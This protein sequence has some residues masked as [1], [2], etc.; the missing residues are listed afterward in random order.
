MLLKDRQSDVLITTISK[1]SN[2]HG[3]ITTIKNCAREAQQRHTLNIIS[4][5][6]LCRALAA[7]VLLSGNLKNCSDL[8]SCHWDCTGEAGSIVTEISYEGKVKG[9][10]DNPHLV[11][12][13]ESFSSSEG[14]D[15][16]YYIGSGQLHVARKTFD[17]RPFYNSITPLDTG[18]IAQDVS[19]Y[20]D[21]SLQVQ[22]ILNLG[23]SIS[24]AN[25]IEACG[26]ILLQAMPDA[27]PDE[28]HRLYEEFLRLDS[29]TTLLQEDISRVKPLF[30]ALDLEIADVRPITFKC[31]CTEEKITGFLR[32]L[33]KTE[34]EHYVIKER[35]IE[36]ACRYCSKI[37]R[38]DADTI[39]T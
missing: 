9:F 23:L 6:L 24:S 1:N 17:N 14:I 10:I 28:I 18:D 21:I 22:S 5:A 11:Y 39:K 15:S 13:E 27:S 16:A 8:L 3:Y 7:T 12:K 4:S 19:I 26:G 38:F 25:T 37:Y 35:Q 29:M 33:D 30:D 36:A 34:L 20:L 31:G 2:I 32:C